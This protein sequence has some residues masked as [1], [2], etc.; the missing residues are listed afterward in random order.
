MRL[1]PATVGLL[2]ALLLP[3]PASADWE[4]SQ[5]GMTR[6]QLMAASQGKAKAC[7]ASD[8]STCYLAMDGCKA[9]AHMQRY[10]AF[11]LTFTVVFG[12]DDK[13]TLAC[14]LLTFE[15]ADSIKDTFLKVYGKP[16]EQTRGSALWTDRT[17]YNSIRLFQ[18][19]DRT[20]IQYRPF[21]K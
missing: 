20:H 14:M 12:F 13:A 4:F 18:V 3:L 5:W 16:D 9:G 6:Q 7:A 11:G 19:R 2:F 21:G 1:L 8:M 17:G 10:P 15:G